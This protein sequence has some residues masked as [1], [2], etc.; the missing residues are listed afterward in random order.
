MGGFVT[1]APRGDGGD[2]R[3]TRVRLGHEG[4]GRLV[5]TVPGDPLRAT[6]EYFVSPAGP[7]VEL[8]VVDV[9]LLRREVLRPETSVFWFDESMNSWKR[10]RITASEREGV[11][12]EQELYCV[13]FPNDQTE[14]IPGPELRVRW[15]HPIEDPFD[16]LAGR[17]TDTPFFFE[18]RRRFVSWVACQ[19][20]AFGGLTGLASA[21]V[22]LLQH[23]VAIVRRILGDPVQRYLLADEVGLGKTIEAGTIVRQHLI[24]DPAGARVVI[25]A[26]D[27]LVQQWQGELRLRFGIP[28]TD[29]R[30]CVVSESTLSVAF[31]GGVVPTLVVVDEA[32]RSAA[33]AFSR[34]DPAI[35]A[36]YATL[37]KL[38]TAAPRVL[39]LTGTPVLRQEDGF[40]AMLHLL[41][42]KAYP[43]ED[44]EGFRE[45]IRNRSAV[46]DAVAQLTDDAGA[47]FVEDAVAQ[48]ERAFG[49]DQQLLTLTREVSTRAEGDFTDPARVAAIR[50][51][52]LHVTETY[53]LDRRL[54]RTRRDDPA[55][56]NLLAVRKGLERI[57]CDDTARCVAW[58]LIEEWRGALPLDGGGGVPP[59]AASVFAD[60]VEAAFSHP[61]AL[62]NRAL[63]RSEELSEVGR[64]LPNGAQSAF[65]DERAW[66][67]RAVTALRGALMSD[68]RATSLAAWLREAKT[69]AIVFVDSPEVADVVIARLG[70]CLGSARV[71]HLGAP[72]EGAT[73]DAVACFVQGDGIQVLVVDRRA[74]EGLNLQET[75]AVVVHYDLPFSLTR[76]EQRNGRVDRLNAKGNPR[77]LAFEGSSQYEEGWL[78]LLEQR[79]R[80][81]HRT[82][83]PLQFLLAESYQRMRERL[84]SEGSHTFSEE[85]ARLGGRGGLEDELRLIR[86]QEALDSLGCDSTE[87]AVLFEGM[88]SADDQ[89]SDDDGKEFESWLCSRL[90][91]QRTGIRDGCVTRDFHYACRLDGRVLL[92]MHAVV[93]NLGRSLDR[94]N[95]DSGL[96]RFGRFTHDRCEAV[97]VNGISILRP[98]NQF[99]DAVEELVRCDDRGAAFALW[100]HDPSLQPGEAH[101]FFR[102]EFVVEADIETARAMVHEAKMATEAL[103]N[104]ADSA[105]APM[106]RTVWVDIEGN[107]VSSQAALAKLEL[108]YEKPRDTNIRP[109]LWAKA[110]AICPVHDWQ[111]LCAKARDAALA[112]LW[113]DTARKVRSD[114]VRRF[115]EKSVAHRVQWQSRVV[116]IPP[117]P[118]RAAEEQAAAYA[119][120]LD[121]CV[122]SGL[123]E[124]RVRVDA[125]GVVYL[126]GT[127]LRDA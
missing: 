101:L 82:V 106:S 113:D 49:D 90:H 91:F 94:G 35:V 36:L 34:S 99:V 59:F 50:S 9:R 93:T 28:K 12:P 27:H 73:L 17:V 5:G 15:A 87:E 19:R 68:P 104:M 117:G 31:V 121:K 127:N 126:S 55:V 11:A 89:A 4:I 122:L 76:I 83:A 103:R 30:V 72:S 52:R 23:Q 46:A 45:R 108:E 24:D 111:G 16:Y 26:P 70:E 118:A 98:G 3:L 92:P 124:P 29:D 1:I 25:V 69:K 115:E 6:V 39:L 56:K 47:M 123:R 38:T 63:A 100:R 80:V 109:D 116:R 78:E 112:T 57:P 7:K 53:K 64:R 74:E 22:D 60:L 125:V 62:A 95:S 105:F 88:C 102:V 43:L 86:N 114:S 13:R 18:G 97:G 51:L 54:L 58:D 10:G 79:V 85:S 8:R 61:Q 42:A 37:K 44:R 65:A 84:V 48:L 120:S 66:C 71:R 119:Q 107:R 75:R 41:D 40:L 77:F 14:I 67:A 96:L 20:A 32:H 81:F 2:P 110:D 33:G 21:A